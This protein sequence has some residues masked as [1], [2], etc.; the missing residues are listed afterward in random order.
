MKENRTLLVVCF[1]NSFLLISYF[2]INEISKRS[3]ADE[4]NEDGVSVWI[5]QPSIFD[6]VMLVFGVFGVVTVIFICVRSYRK[7]V[8]LGSGVSF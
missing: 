6:W 5:S 2:I 3:R 8:A 7:R 1:I 4:L